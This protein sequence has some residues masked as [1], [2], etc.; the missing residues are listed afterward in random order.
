V[1]AAAIAAIAVG[2]SWLIFSAVMSGRSVVAHPSNKPG[3]PAHFVPFVKP[4]ALTIGKA[5]DIYVSDNRCPI[6][7]G[8]CLPPLSDRLLKLSPSGIV[9]GSWD[10]AFQLQGPAGLARDGSGNIYVVETTAHRI[11]KL[12][13]KGKLLAHWGSEGTRPGQL[14]SPIGLAVNRQNDIF[15]ADTGNH[16]IQ[17]LSPSGHVIRIWGSQGHGAGQFEY[18]SGIAVDTQGNLYVADTINN[19]VQKFSPTGTFISQWGHTGGGRGSLRGPLG[20]TVGSNGNVY[21]ADTGNDRVQQFSATGRSLASWGRFGVRP[22]QFNNPTAVS[23]DS[24]GNLFVVDAGNARVQKFSAAGSPLAQWGK[25][26]IVA[27]L[28][29]EVPAGTPGMATMSRAILNGVRLATA[30][31]KA[32]FAGVSLDLS[33]PRSLAE[34]FDP[35]HEVRNARAC[36]RR[37]DTFGYIG[38]VSSG[39][40]LSVEPVL[41]AGG[42]ATISPANTGPALTD[43]KQRRQLEPATFRHKLTHLTYYRIVPTER[44]LGPAAAS[45]MR[46][47]PGVRSY[48]AVD[49]GT[50]YE[51]AIVSDLGATRTWSARLHRVGVGHLVLADPAT[52]YRTSQA[53]A[54]RILAKHPDGVYCACDA[55]AAAQFAHS[56]RAKGY[57]KPIVGSDASFE[58]SGAWTGKRYGE[59]YATSVGLPRPLNASQAFVIAYRNA[60]HQGP[61]PWALPG[62]KAANIALNGLYAADKAGRFR[63]TLSHMREAI[64]PYVA[65]ARFSDGQRLTTFDKNGDVADPSVSVYALQ[66]GRW[67]F[68]T[69]VH[70]ASARVR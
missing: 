10:K 47:R 19:R 44:L 55:G 22:A 24:H 43:P 53:L 6:S 25:R 69:A 34:S 50:S 27:R 20:L 17:E 15:V 65:H 64:L 5:G 67:R 8:V 68:F 36:L 35:G 11:T 13:P 4:M 54:D 9:I 56:L 33:A 18:P 58:A 51:R 31:R 37:S 14:E 40:A 66:H 62:F 70:P 3:L 7:A 28:C 41:N 49:D 21:V 46:Q 29:V 63:G 16:R 26:V 30:Q 39:D 48:Y 2:A 38:P 1:G 61:D 52:M 57:Y 12:S 59:V 42:M 32:R 45:F 60:F 23:T